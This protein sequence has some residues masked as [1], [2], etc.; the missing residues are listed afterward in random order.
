M[1]PDEWIDE[2]LAALAT[3]HQRRSLDVNTGHMRLNFATN[4]YLNFANHPV[5]KQ[6]AADAL[7]QYGTG[8]GASRL[9]S[10]TLPIHEEVEAV[11][12][13]AKGY[14]AALLFGSGYLTSIG[15][16]PPLAGRDDTIFADRLIHACLLDGIQLS[17]AKLI[18]FQHND[19]D[20]LAAELEK[21][22]GKGRKLI[23]T[24]SVFSMD[25]DIAPLTEIA[26]LAEQHN[27]MLMVDEAHATGVF[28]PLGSGLVAENGLQH[29]V[30][31]S[32]S[33]FSKALGGYGGIVACSA[34]IRE[35][36]INKS[37]SFIYTTA[38]PPPVCGAII[39]AVKLLET[40]PTL[41][42][43]LLARA[44]RFRKLLNEA[45]FN[46]GN[47]RSQIV[48]VIIGD[49]ETTMAIAANLKQKGI[50]VG[51][52]RPPTVPAGTARLRFSITLAHTENDLHYTADELV[53]AAHA[54]GWKK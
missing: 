32:M 17:G 7:A 28:G 40:E 6:A 53:R 21:H 15:C 10:G 23:V 29:L 44:E 39:A 27:A 3:Q 37:R 36:L 35:W 51:A 31:A 45:G 42:K 50:W 16:I 33:T 5:L 30:N 38:P 20:D 41:G 47:S 49:N 4:D 46:T 22:S 8:S 14:P 2:K 54:C 13:R 34:K 24:E 18:R 1:K 48:P 25:G 12:A 43:T 52:I 26:R 11:V 19:A 9:V